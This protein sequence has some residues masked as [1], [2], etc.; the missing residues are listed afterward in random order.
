V[1]SVKVDK[2]F[3]DFFE[4][5]GLFYK[6][7]SKTDRKITWVKELGLAEIEFFNNKG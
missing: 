5:F 1:N 2:T 7:E 6:N 4:K 3:E